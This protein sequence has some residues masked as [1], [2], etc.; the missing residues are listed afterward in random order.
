MISG[1]SLI[2]ESLPTDIGLGYD[3]EGGRIFLRIRFFL[4]IWIFKNIIRKSDYKTP[5]TIRD[6]KKWRGKYQSSAKSISL[7]LC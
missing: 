2:A 7:A 6:R 3:S 1:K 4:I 5:T